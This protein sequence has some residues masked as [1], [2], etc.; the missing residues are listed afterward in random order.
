MRPWGVRRL[1]RFPFRTT[2]DVRADI[3]EEFA[4]HLDMRTADL[5]RTGLSERDARAQALR[6]FGDATA[7]AADC[8]RHDER[9][10]RRLAL[11][12]WLGELRQDLAIGWRLLVRSPGFASIAILTLALGL[13]ATV[14]IFSALDAVL[15]RPLPYPEPDRLVQVFETLENGSLNSVSGGAFLDWRRDQRAF[16]SLTLVGRVTYNLRGRGAPERVQGLEA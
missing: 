1:F 12:R 2:D 13:A 16:D 15:L 6:E 3:R 7:G 5:M 11:A 4:F 10:E 8:S 9:L 14:T